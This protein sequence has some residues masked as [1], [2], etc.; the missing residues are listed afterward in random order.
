MSSEHSAAFDRVVD[1]LRSAPASRRRDLLAD[2]LQ[3]QL[4]YAI[5]VEPA[6]VGPQDPMMDL[7]VDSLKAVELKM[8]LEDE[9]GIELGSSLMFDYPTIEA[10]TGFLLQTLELD[11][12]A[13]APQA[14][15]ATV[16]MPST[17]RPADADAGVANLSPD[18]VVALLAAELAS[19]D[20]VD[21]ETDR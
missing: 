20:R 8:Y 14:A 5:G 21:G 6:L 18:E 1:R 9:L 7:G 11:F 19:I 17:R 4:A 12:G 2:F 16:R 3:E 13:T 10:L 15:T